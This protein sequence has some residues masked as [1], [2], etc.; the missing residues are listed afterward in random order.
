EVGFNEPKRSFDAGGT[1]RVAALMRYEAKPEA[2]SKGFH[3]RHRDHFFA[4]AAQHHHM[5]VVDHHTFYRSAHIAQRIGEKNLA[6]E[7]LKRRVDL[8][9]QH[10]RVTQHRRSGLRLV[11][12]AGHLHLVRRGVVLQLHAGLEVILTNR[13]DWSLTDA[14]LAAKRSQRR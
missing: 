9:E 2:F 11:L 7:T 1:I 6:I 13:Y 10:A 5:R 4:R 8:E 3:F 12:P 14:L